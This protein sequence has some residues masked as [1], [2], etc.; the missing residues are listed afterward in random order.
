MSH[1]SKPKLKPAHEVFHR[2]MWDPI[3]PSYDITILYE[4]RFKK[5]LIEVPF[6]GWDY[7]VPM[8]RVRQFKYQDKV[9]WDRT[10]RIDLFPIFFSKN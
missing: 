8:H 6:D 4:D 9:I 10:E 1:N 2:V 5:D 3:I 7:V